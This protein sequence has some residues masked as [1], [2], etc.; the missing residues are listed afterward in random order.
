MGRERERGRHLGNSLVLEEGDDEGAK[1]PAR[2]PPKRSSNHAGMQA[3][4]C[5]L[6]PPQALG[7]PLCEQDIGCDRAQQ[8]TAQ[9][10]AEQ[11]TSLTPSLDATA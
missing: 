7:E 8:G 10:M 11:T 1:P 6:R 5:D 4:G 2:L 3:S 9:S